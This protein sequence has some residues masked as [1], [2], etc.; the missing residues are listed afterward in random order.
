MAKNENK[1]AEVTESTDGMKIVAHGPADETNEASI[2]R[3]KRADGRKN[4]ID[5]MAG[6]IL[7]VGEDLTQEEADNLLNLSNWN[8]ERV[9]E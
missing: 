9:S 3:Y 7:T 5:I 2:L 4:D 6:Q 1:E 8:F